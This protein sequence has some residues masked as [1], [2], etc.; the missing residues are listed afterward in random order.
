MK[1]IGEHLDSAVHGILRE[2]AARDVIE[3][4]RRIDGPAGAGCPFCA[5]RDIGSAGTALHRNQLVEHSICRRCGEHFLC[6]PYDE[7]APSDSSDPR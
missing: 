7:A 4:Y 1:N 6:D 3:H 2:T 5:S